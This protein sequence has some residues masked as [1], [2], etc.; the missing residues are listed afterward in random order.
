[1]ASEGL[2]HAPRVG[3]ATFNSMGWH[4]VLFSSSSGASFGVLNGRFREFPESSIRNS[5]PIGRVLC[6]AVSASLPDFSSASLRWE[7]FC[8][9]GRPAMPV[10]LLLGGLPVVCEHISLF[11]FRSLKPGAAAC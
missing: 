2:P 10:R 4:F 7:F 5:L 8:W 9:Y 3:A 6:F 1:M 11:Y